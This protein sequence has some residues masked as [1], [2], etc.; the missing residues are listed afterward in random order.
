MVA[1]ARPVLQESL[2][3]ELRWRLREYF[4]RTRHLSRA[5]EDQNLIRDMSPRLQGEVLF[6]VCKAWLP[7]VGYQPPVL[8]EEC[9]C[10]G[11]FACPLTQASCWTTPHHS[12]TQVAFLRDT[13]P[14]FIAKVVLS[15][16]PLVFAPSDMVLGTQLYVL[17]HGVVLYGGR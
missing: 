13:D 10:R 9:A 12:Q 11:A 1:S 14:E 6:V 4:Q 15:F 2:P 16:K 17:Y 8:R 3:S 5:V 7:K